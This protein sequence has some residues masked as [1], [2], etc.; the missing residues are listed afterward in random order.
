MAFF[1]FV[2]QRLEPRTRDLFYVP[3]LRVDRVSLAK[4]YSIAELFRS[5]LT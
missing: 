3:V 4:R 1:L 2:I 5:S